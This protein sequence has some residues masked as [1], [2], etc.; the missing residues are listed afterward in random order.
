MANITPAAVYPVS[1]SF[2]TTP[3]YSGTFIPSIWSGKLNAKFYAASTFN[4]IS[5]SN[6]EG[7]ISGIGDKVI[8]NNIPTVAVSDYTV[9]GS[10]SYEVLTP[11]TIELVIDQGKAF[12]FQLNDVL[13]YQS[14]PDLMNMFSD[15]AAEQMKTQIDANCWF[16]TFD[17]GAAANMG[18]NAGAISGAYNLGTDAAPIALASDNILSKILAM[19]SVMDEQNIPDTGRWLVMTPQDRY[20]LMQSPLAQAYYTGDST[21]PIRNGK[22]GMIDRFE[23][24]V[25]NLL[26]RGAADKAWVSGVSDPA[27]GAADVGAAARHCM[28]AGHNTALTFAAQISKTETLRN[29][30]DFGDYVRGLSVF[31]RRCVKPESLVLLTAAG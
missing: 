10:L 24:Y 7:E 17:Q 16:A 5:N 18:A 28:V 2:A 20:I 4:A 6:W 12:S 25:S 30:T 21:S 23:L 19:A 3:S 26:P 1:G 11:D 15:D 27:T 29:P 13:K 22:V 9:G 8:I 14:K 31:G